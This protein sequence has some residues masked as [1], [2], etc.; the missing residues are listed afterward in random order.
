[1]LHAAREI[2]KNCKNQFLVTDNI[3]CHRNKSKIYF[4]RIKWICF[5]SRVNYNKSLKFRFM[6]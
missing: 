3:R 2:G 1:M 6:I 4:F 5:C